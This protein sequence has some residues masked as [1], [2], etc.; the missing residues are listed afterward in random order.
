MT[1]RKPNFI[2][3]IGRTEFIVAYRFGIGEDNVNY[4]TL[5]SFPFSR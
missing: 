3:L 2:L 1:E 5:R 4:F